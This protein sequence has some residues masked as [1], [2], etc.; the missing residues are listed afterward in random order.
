[1][2]RKLSRFDS[3]R[4]LAPAFS[5]ALCLATALLAISA[6]TA[7]AAPPEL[8]TTCQA[9]AEAGQCNTP[10]GVAANPDNGHVFVADQNNHRVNELN[11]LG[12]F[13]KA[14]GWGV[15]TGAAELQTCTTTS[16]CQTGLEGTGDGQLSAI[17]PGIALDSAGNVYVVDRGFLGDPSVRVQ[18]YSPDG[19]FLLTFG[20]EVNKTKTEEV[21]STEAERNLC[22]AASGDTCQKGT[23][24]SG[25]G[26]FGE[27]PIG[28]FITVDDNGTDTDSDDK[29]LVGDVNRIQVFDTGGVYQEEL[30]LPVSGTVQG[31]DVDPAGNLYAIY[32]S[33]VHKLSPTGAPL[34]LTLE[35]EVP[36]PGAVALSAESHI[37]VFGA[38]SFNGNP[39]DPLFEFD[40]DGSLIDNW[41]KGEFAASTGIAANLCEGSEA[42][43]NLYVT[44]ADASA[45]FLR[46]YGTDPVGCF[47]A[48]TGEASNV[49]ENSATLNGTV[50]PDGSLV[51]ECR[52]EYGTDTAYGTTVPCVESP[53][54]IGEGTEPVAVH[55]DISGLAKG[56]VYH[57][58]LLAKVGGEAETGADEDFKT[59]G[60]PVISEDRTVSAS[61]TEATLKA[62]V[63]PEG[64]DAT[65]HFE[66]GTSAAYGQSTAEIPIGKDRTDHPVSVTLRGLTPGTAYHWR[67]VADNSSGSDEGDDHT[68]TTHRLPGSEPDS[69]PNRGFRTADSA[70]LPDCR[71]YEMV[72]PVDK[73]GGDILT[74]LSG[75]AEP[76]DAGG[77]V[78]ASLD[79]ARITYTAV[80]ASF[81]GQPNNFRFNQYLGERGSG[82]WASRGIHPRV[83]GRRVDISL[84]GLF[85]EFIAFTPDLCSTWLVDFQTPTL[86]PDAQQGFRNLYRRD[87]CAPGEG[88]LEAMVPSPPQLPLGTDESYVDQ[89][90][91]QGI[92]ADGSHALFTAKAKLSEEA[93]PSDAD[94]QV[95]DR[96]GGANHLVSV[97]PDGSA[98]DPAP[99]NGMGFADPAPS[100]V[101]NSASFNLQDAVSADGSRVYWTSGITGSTGRLFL[102]LHPEQGIVAGECTT[103]AKA[104]TL[105]VSVGNGAF[106]WRG[107]PDG[108]KALFSEET[109][110][111]A[112]ANLYEFDLQRAQAEE[113]PR[114]IANHVRGVAGT[115]DD[116]SRVYFVSRDA[117][118]GAGSNS[119]GDEA[120]A[121][122]PNLYL[123]EGG[124]LSFVATLVDADLAEVEP[125]ANSP[126]YSPVENFPVYRASRV[127]PDGTRIAFESR[128][129]LT[130]YDNAGAQ[131]GRAA[132]EVFTYAVGGE[133]ACVS[134]NPSGGRPSSRELRSPYKAPFETLLLTN[135]PAAAWIATWEHSLHDSNVLSEDGSRLFFNSNDALVPRD[136]NGTGDVYEWE[137]A[138]T[139]S[140]E[141]G[142]AA[143]VPENGG[144]IYLISSGVSSFESEFREATPDGSDV[145]FTTAS[146][147]LPQDPGSVDLYDAR[148]GG[149]FPQ[150][151]QPAPCEGEACQS[152]P[153]PPQFPTPASST[154]SGPG[155][156]K[157]KKPCPKG[158]HRVK[159]KGK[160]RCVPKRQKKHKGRAANPNQRTG[161]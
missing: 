87:N 58:R 53:A 10:R 79:G 43:G 44:N 15:D 130:G 89:K 76:P 30:P 110:P 84:F 160:A 151:I 158:K 145:F 28:D 72:S 88:G 115:S 42:P 65:Y 121:G 47:K 21:G 2:S 139:G 36:F 38:V 16:G 126:A 156:P 78:Q 37:F 50:N 33:E 133:L 26:Q 11:A 19:E 91:V 49:Q 122:Q 108:S 68:L 137:A 6:S 95:Y 29:V 127:T 40:S 138:G 82:G 131:D 54:Q 135:V 99:G 96:F 113:A 8:W 109:I 3:S 74:A 75:T 51:S 18:K 62:L 55:A 41:G 102:R 39:S 73:N 90:S 20:G 119:E 23:V 25:Q 101:G 63:N 136:T 35:V 124:A 98:G 100:A 94:T 112:G 5:L 149:G 120:Q 7:S 92:S 157:H 86:T 85:R 70:L 31:L 93:A 128:G 104:C 69:C 14:W 107:T 27:W 66:Y 22:T 123:A 64:F 155:T 57:F 48:R 144:C 12:Q 45:A 71:A 161:R 114:L 24:G 117:L 111:G 17:A 129:S 46:A 61:Y 143:F 150:P 154:Y 148:V 142:A 159:R 97:R 132:V 141:E 52:F 56:T 146:S 106:F 125:G 13:I 147:L 1:V 103:A 59:L 77:Y 134:C 9:G 153:P 80:Y 60:P 118:P 81:A 83:D 34:S 152:P 116:L 105:P 4:R 67:I 140:C 32:G